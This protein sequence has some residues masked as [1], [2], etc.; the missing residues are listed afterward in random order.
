MD[1]I[2]TY[3]DGTTILHEA[4]EYEGINRVEQSIAPERGWQSGIN[5]FHSVNRRTQEK[6]IHWIE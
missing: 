1:D 6:K 4:T 2:N 5:R 3:R